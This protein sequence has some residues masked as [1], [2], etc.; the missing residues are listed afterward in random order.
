MAAYGLDNGVGIVPPMGFNTFKVFG[1]QGLNETVV[2]TQAQLMVSMGLRDLGYTYMNIDDCWS[3]QQRD[4]NSHIQADPKKF[5]S[6]MASMG[7]YLHSNGLNF[8]LFSAAGIK[9]CLSGAGSLAY[10]QYDAGD[11]ANWGVDFL[12]YGDCNG[13]GIPQRS[14]FMTMRDALNK[15]GRPVFYSLAKG[16]IAGSASVNGSQLAN[17]WR[18]SVKVFDNFWDNVRSSFQVNNYFA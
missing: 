14:R 11:F 10:E 9:S 12:K 17:S 18:S 6:G 1:C 16:D 13:I 7:T 2:K 5:P 4:S 15:T 8:G 3:L